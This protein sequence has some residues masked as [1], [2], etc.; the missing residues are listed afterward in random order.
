MR[1]LRLARRL[2]LGSPTLRRCRRAREAAPRPR[3][4]PASWL[5]NGARAD[6]CAAAPSPD[7]G[8][9]RRLDG[10]RGARGARRRSSRSR[11]G[12]SRAPT[13][14]RTSSGTRSRSSSSPPTWS[15][16]RS[17]LPLGNCAGRVRE[18]LDTPLADDLTRG[19]GAGPAR[20]A[21][22]HGQAG[23]ARRHGGGPRKPR[24]RPPRRRDGRRPDAAA[25]DLDEAPEFSR[26]LHAHASSPGVHGAPHPPVASRQIDRYLRATAPWEVE[27]IVLSVADRLATRGPRTSESAV[28]RHLALAREVMD[29]TSTSVDRG[30]VQPLL[31]GDEAAADLGRPARAVARRAPR[32]AARGA[33]RR[34]RPHQGAGAAVRAH[35]ERGPH[36]GEPGR[37]A[38]R[39]RLVAVVRET[40]SE[41]CDTACQAI[42]VRAARRTNRCPQTPGEGH[43]MGSVARRAGIVSG[44]AALAL[45]ERRRRGRGGPAPVRRHRSRRARR[46]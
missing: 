36:L 24:P 29:V 20:P 9:F 19:P 30:P 12:W 33:G 34:R 43:A 40:A 3:D 46:R 28:R 38:G 27:I 6:P 42:R 10:A 41:P 25:A 5:A 8:G 17:G 2:S 45:V 1:S 11:A 22:R 13:T 35:L 39:N 23:H 37:S 32:A 18:V 14:T 16:T 21:P 26:P 31:A 7:R 4:A 44:L 15:P